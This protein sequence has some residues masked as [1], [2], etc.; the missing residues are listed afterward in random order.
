MAARE[1]AGSNPPRRDLHPIACSPVHAFAS[2][3]IPILR[4]IAL[5]PKPSTSSVPPP[6]TLF[7]CLP[8]QFQAGAAEPLQSMADGCFGQ[9]QVW[10]PGDMALDAFRWYSQEG[11]F[12]ESFDVDHLWDAL[13]GKRNCSELGGPG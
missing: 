13:H 9:S 2:T 3:P 8:P 6:L 4:W 12:W 7:Y 10:R 11:E 1:E 5:I